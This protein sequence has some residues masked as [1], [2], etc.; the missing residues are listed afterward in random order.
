VLRHRGY[1]V[2]PDLPEDFRLKDVNTQAE[3]FNEGEE[4]PEDDFADLIPTEGIVR[5]RIDFGY[6]GTDFAGWAKQPG[7]RTI[8]GTLEQ[9]FAQVLRMDVSPRIVVAGRTDAGVHAA[10]QV[11]HVDIPLEQLIRVSY[12]RLERRELQEQ[13]GIAFVGGLAQIP[14]SM[15][16]ALLR[17]VNGS[18][19]RNT[20]VVINRVRVAPVGFDARFSPLARRYEYRIADGLE[21]QNPI[22]RR[23]TTFNF[24]PLD[25]A[26]MNQAAEM[27]LGLRDFGAFCR[28]RPGATTIRELQEFHWERG[29]DGVI[30]ATLQADAF[31][32]SMVRSLVGACV[33]AGSAANT[34]DEIEELRSQG[35]RTSVFKVMPALGLTLLEIVYPPDDQVGERAELTRSRRVLEDD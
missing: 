28:P 21:H 1:V 31:C 3:E 20:D 16:H 33:A 10:A 2:K 27:M 35:E 25:V 12:S 30:V 8:E 6:D 24:Y 17:R 9:A 5:V 14:P 7:L 19:G 23:K 18:I 13:G 34:L 26:A 15:L 32:H 4:E 22:E 11:A 29:A